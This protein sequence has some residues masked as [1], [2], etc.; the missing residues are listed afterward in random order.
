MIERTLYNGLISGLSLD[1]QKFFYPNALESDGTYEFNQGACTRKDWFDCSC[2]PTNVIRFIPS[3]PG[4]IYS[5]SES[6]IYVDLYASNTAD[7]EFQDQVIQVSQK[8]A[9]PWNGMVEIAVEPQ[10]PAEFE[11]KLRVPGWA[12]NEVLPGNLYQYSSKMEEMPEVMVNGKKMT[13]EIVAGYLV[14]DRKWEES[15]TIV[16]DFPMQVREVLADDKV[17]DDRGKVSLEYGPIVYA[18]EEVDNKDN[19]EELQIT[20]QTNFSVQFEK[21][22]L[23]GVNTLK[24]DDFKAIPYYSWSNRGIGKMKVWLKNNTKDRT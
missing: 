10:K 6:A 9:Y 5:K 7:I 21:D 16:L 11:L 15:T 22:L 14:M 20:P 1:G 24:F 19:F 18:V 4:L 12:R 13:A 8:T 23:Q 2:C 17:E 3:I